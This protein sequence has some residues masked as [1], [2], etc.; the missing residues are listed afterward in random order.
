ML[1]ITYTLNL[2]QLLKIIPKL[3]RYLWMKMKPNKR[4]NVPKIIIEKIV[5]FLVPKVTTTIITIDNHMV[6]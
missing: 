1:E 5:P 6:I 2:G 3:K 4:Y